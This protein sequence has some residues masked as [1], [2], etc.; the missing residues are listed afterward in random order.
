MCVNSNQA[1]CAQRG[2]VGCSYPGFPCIRACADSPTGR[3]IPF[4]KSCGV[5]DPLTGT[6]LFISSASATC[7]VTPAATP[8]TT[9]AAAEGTC[10]ARGTCV[11]CGANG[12]SIP[13]LP[14]QPT[15]ACSYQAES[16]GPCTDPCGG[17]SRSFSYICKCVDGTT[18]ATGRRCAGQ[19]RA[20]DI[21][22]CFTDKCP[23]TSAETLSLDAKVPLS[24]FD[25]SDFENLVKSVLQR[26]V[27]V[28]DFSGLSST[29]TR[30][31]LRSC[32]VD[33]AG[34]LDTATLASLFNLQSSLLA[35]SLGY[36]YSQIDESDNSF[37]MALIAVIV[38]CVIGFVIIVAALVYYVKARSQI[39][40]REQRRAAREA[41][42]RLRKEQKTQKAK[43][44]F[45]QQQEDKEK[46]T[47]PPKTP[48]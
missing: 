25:K 48:S 45:L 17:G 4:D 35:A 40:K 18:D 34:C 47:P 37:P 14:T 3:C 43:Y 19:P 33:G 44:G 12:C 11:A 46:K 32:R 28:T 23:T 8:C 36:S 5:L 15:P 38:V 10:N 27:A 22:P 39:K 2:L 20:F 6:A 1:F 16:T 31:R 30:V 41:R 13:V 24:T 21:E 42:R 7:S 26:P 9:S 29:S